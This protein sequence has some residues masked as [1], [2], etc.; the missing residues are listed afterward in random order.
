MPKRARILIADDEDTLRKVVLMT[1]EQ[2]GYSA[3]G[4][5]NGKE[6]VALV[7]QEHIDLAIVD[8]I[9]P[10]KEGLETIVELRRIQPAI[11][12]IAISGGGH[13]D[14]K[15][16]LRMASQLG[17]VRTLPK[18]FSREQLLGAV[19]EVLGSTG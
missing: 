13:G 2:D 3:I 10:E 11:K 16:Y 7:R 8:L 9:M 1:L 12:I 18:P 4:A 19:T 6:S 5:R 15:D 14:P 17:A